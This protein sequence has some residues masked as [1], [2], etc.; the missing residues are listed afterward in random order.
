MASKQIGVA[1]DIYH[2]ELKV[3]IAYRDKKIQSS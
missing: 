3:T 2:L 1:K